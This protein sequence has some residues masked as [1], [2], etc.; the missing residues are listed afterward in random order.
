MRDQTIGWPGFTQPRDSIKPPLPWPTFAPALTARCD[1]CQ[2]TS[3]HYCSCRNRHY[4]KYPGSQ[5][6]EWLEAR[7][8]EL[9]EV[10]YFHV[11][12]TMPPKIAAIAYQNK[13]VL[14][15]LLFKASAETLATIA[16]VPK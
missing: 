10:P 7:K 14:S 2:H 6:P 16:A 12:F 5:A 9:L 11:V 4:L 15:D 3:I 1:K 13:A 8:T